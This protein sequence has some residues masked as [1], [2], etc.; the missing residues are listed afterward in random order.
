MASDTVT[1]SHRIDAPAADIFAILADPCRHPEFDGSQMLREAV[2]DAVIA[3][4]G[5]VFIMKMYYPTLGDYEMNNHVVEYELNRRIGWEPQAGCGHPDS[6]APH[7]RWGQRWSFELLSDG[8]EATVVTEIYDCSAAPEEERAS[9]DDGR[10]W[11]EAMTQT[12]RR[13]EELVQNN[14]LRITR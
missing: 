8:P 9:M 1:V 5:D 6:S 2:T 14:R 3:K 11:I 7:A 13:L 4:V 12:L 10:I